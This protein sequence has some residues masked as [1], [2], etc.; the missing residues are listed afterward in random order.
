MNLNATHDVGLKQ[1]ERDATTLSEFRNNTAK[2]RTKYKWSYRTN[3]EHKQN[4]SQTPIFITKK[5][6]I[7]I[8]YFYSHLSKQRRTIPTLTKVFKYLTE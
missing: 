2:E 4:K 5:I 7:H 6:V 8:P 3:I 1:A